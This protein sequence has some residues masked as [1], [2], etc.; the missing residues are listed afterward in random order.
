M[1]NEDLKL[2]SI[3]LTTTQPSSAPVSS[4]VSSGHSSKVESI[5]EK[6]RQY[7]K[8]GVLLDLNDVQLKD[9]YEQISQL[10]KE[11]MAQ[12]ISEIPIDGSKALAKTVLSDIEVLEHI[13][14]KQPE[15]IDKTDLSATQASEGAGAPNSLSSNKEDLA[16][17]LINLYK[18]TAEH[19]K[20]IDKLQKS[21]EISADNA[22]KSKVKYG[23]IALHDFGKVI[24]ER[25]REAIKRH[26]IE[27]IQVTDSDSG[28]NY[29]T[30]AYQ[31]DKQKAAGY[32]MEYAKNMF[33]YG[34]PSH[35]LEE[36]NEL[37]KEQIADYIK[38]NDIESIA[39]KLLKKSVNT[40]RGFSISISGDNSAEALLQLKM[41]ELQA[42]NSKGMSVE[43]FNQQDEMT[44]CLDIIDMISQKEDK[45][46][47]TATEKFALN[48]AET[49][50]KAILSHFAKI[51]EETGKQVD[52]PDLDKLSYTEMFNILKDTN[53]VNK[54]ATW[55]ET[56][57]SEKSENGEKL[58]DYEQV[59]LK[60]L[61]A[62][63][64]YL[65]EMFGTNLGK[66]S[67]L[68]EE[69]GN[70]EK[71]QEKYANASY[72]EKAELAANYFVE[73]YG[74]NPE[75]FMAYLKN[76][77]E[78]G[79]I[80]QVQALVSKLSNNALPECYKA[81]IAKMDGNKDFV[82]ILTSMV[83]HKNMKNS[84]AAILQVKLSNLNDEAIRNGDAA[85]EKANDVE[86][87]YL[88]DCN[89]EQQLEISKN[90]GQCSER[91]Q[92]LTV[93]CIFSSENQAIMNDSTAEQ[94]SKNV[95]ELGCDSAKDV[96]VQSAKNDKISS[97]RRSRIFSAMV[98]ADKTGYS[99]K[100]GV[101]EHVVATLDKADQKDVY[102][103]QQ[104]AIDS[105]LQKDEAIKYG[106]ALADQIV[107]C[108]SSNQAAL[109]SISTNS[110]YE[111]VAVYAAS[112]IHKYAESAQAEAL[113]ISYATNNQR[114]IEAATVQLPKMSETAVAAIKEVVAVQI[115]A[116]EER[117]SASMIDEYAIRQIKKQLGF[118]VDTSKPEYKTKLEAYIAELKKL[119]R[120]ELYRRIIV[121]M[122]SWP[123]DIQSSFLEAI[124]KYCPQLFSMMLEKYG[125][126]L[127]SSFGQINVLTK[128]EILTQMLKSPSQRSE[129]ISY[130]KS[131]PN[132]SYSDN[133]R[134]LYD[135][136]IDDLIS[137]G[138]LVDSVAPKALSTN[139][140][141]YHQEHN[142]DYTK[143]ES[144][145]VGIGERLNWNIK[146]DVYGKMGL[147]S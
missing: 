9:L 83:D 74:D 11:E 38:E 52:I 121:D 115:K 106:K 128:N 105:Y 5:F 72:T 56:Y 18:N 126:K 49:I 141:R 65:L 54:V 20:N 7:N 63:P 69:A 84:D 87:K 1:A 37:S 116:M 8:E 14:D 27:S 33:L 47:L 79:N 139:S 88:S 40:L 94:I 70:D 123:T 21:G 136:I 39:N 32:V 64:S 48:Q 125:I 58:T 144:S 23:K 99:A 2:N 57:L 25:V 41:L 146:T 44:Q 143:G 127:L 103:V 89:Q 80:V 51:C 66:I 119:P 135:E 73:H 30:K 110:K 98:K 147:V 12:L 122:Q 26:K 124:V 85:V 78:C 91:S 3:K 117:H 36:W 90:L 6:F 142:I 86:Q 113:K 130:I 31:Q 140:E 35:Q 120:T 82:A 102:V 45:S 28:T 55:L 129:A 19:I 101:E 67:L 61:S 62:M 75:Q 53:Q 145:I 137:S 138:V 104:Q 76:A 59:T 34:S 118:D 77:L 107:E 100:R 4:V 42:A 15:D 17:A 108:D 134:K 96:V 81:L 68:D 109:H 16:L 46:K 133:L 97:N 111:E 131:N 132:G 71:L 10:S 22:K 95:A 60:I 24:H 13:P 29:N 112:N 92:I 43:E 50:K 114:I 93:E